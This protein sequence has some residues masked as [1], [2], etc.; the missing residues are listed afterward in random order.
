[1]CA[2]QNIAL[3]GHRG[4]DEAI[5]G[6]SE[7]AANNGNFRPILRYRM[8]GGDVALLNHV[9]GASANVTYLSPTIQNELPVVAADLVREK[10]LA[11]VR[12]AGCWALIADETLDL[13][14]ESN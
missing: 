9:I 6:C 11:R 2:R 10:I 14:N 1:M 7:P 13:Q 8:R 5:V 3:R 12:Q 4:E